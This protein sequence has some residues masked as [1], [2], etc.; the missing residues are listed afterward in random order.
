MQEMTHPTHRNRSRRAMQLLGL[1]S[2]LL[3]LSLFALQNWLTSN[4]LFEVWI[5]AL[6]LCF[7]GFALVGIGREHLGRCPRCKRLIHASFFAQ[8]EGEAIKLPCTCCQ[9]SWNIGIV[10]RSGD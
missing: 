3:F 9:V 6:I 1:I 2:A 7:L 5:L 10:S 4:A 8:T